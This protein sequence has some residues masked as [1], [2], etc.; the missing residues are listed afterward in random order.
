MSANPGASLWGTHTGF[1]TPAGSRASARLAAGVALEAGTV[2]NQR[3]LSAVLAHVTL[4]AAE[5]CTSR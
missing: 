4:V 3:V 1:G 2:A 5:S